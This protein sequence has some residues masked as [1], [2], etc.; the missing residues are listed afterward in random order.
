MTSIFFFLHNEWVNY[1]AP[2][3]ISND[4]TGYT[5]TSHTRLPSKKNHSYFSTYCVLN[6]VLLKIK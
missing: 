3:K 6:E 4:V 2:T 5:H 1:L